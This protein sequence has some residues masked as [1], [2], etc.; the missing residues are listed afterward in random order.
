MAPEARGKR[1]SRDKLEKLSKGTHGIP[2]LVAK[3]VLSITLCF[4]GIRFAGF[5]AP[6]KASM[7]LLDSSFGEF[8][9]ECGVPSRYWL[10]SY[11]Q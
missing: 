11:C 10:M 7:L 1:G 3:F 9:S 5:T 8:W 2:V 6:R 4:A